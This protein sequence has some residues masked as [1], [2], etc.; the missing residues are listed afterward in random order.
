MRSIQ[1]PIVRILVLL[2]V[3]VPLSG[4]IWF[5]ITQLPLP[6]WVGIG[7]YDTKTTITTDSAQ[8]QTVEVERQTRRTYWDLLALLV[9]PLTL[10][11][12]GVLGTD[13]LNKQQ[14]DRQA[15][16]DTRRNRQQRRYDKVRDARMEKVERERKDRELVE[17]TRR[18]QD[19]VLQTY[20]ANMTELLVSKGLATAELDAPVRRAANAY[21]LYAF[22]FLDTSHK[23][24][25][26]RYL[27]SA[28]LAFGENTI[29]SL[30]GLDLRDLPLSGI[31]FSGANLEKVNWANANLRGVD[32]SETKL[33]SANLAG[34]DLSET[35][36]HGA[37]LRNAILTKANL[38]RAKFHKNPLDDIADEEYKKLPEAARRKYKWEEAEEF[39]RF[40]VGLNDETRQQLNEQTTQIVEMQINHTEDELASLRMQR[41]LLTGRLDPERL[42]GIQAREEELERE[43]MKKLHGEATETQDETSMPTHERKLTNQE[44]S[45]RLEEFDTKELELE[46]KLKRLKIELETTVGANLEGAILKNADLR[47]SYIR[48]AYLARANLIGTDLRGALITHTDLTGADLTGS[49]LD[50]AVLYKV[51]VTQKQLAKA[52]TVEGAWHDG[53]TLRNRDVYPNN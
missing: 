29:L 11:V 2:L 53:R 47:D 24:Q 48:Y 5:L 37:H 17:T 8:N 7:P 32:L 21:N 19:A 39:L 43:L 27:E 1:H 36:L 33:D 15:D 46:A 50:G 40:I 4:G 28:G 41:D 45:D 49:K 12:G 35:L 20:L 34:A 14:Q 30:V 51:T 13:W 3:I 25:I 38:Q 22:N 23:M 44:W 18:E 52:A 6:E 10:A 31:K 26:V 16:Y 42:K 9:L